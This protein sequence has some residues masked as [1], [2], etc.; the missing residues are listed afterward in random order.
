[1]TASPFENVSPG[2]QRGQMTSTILQCSTYTALLN[3]S[4]LVK[5]QGQC[6]RRQTFPERSKHFWKAAVTWSSRFIMQ[7]RAHTVTRGRPLRCSHTPL[8]A[9]FV[10]CFHG[11]VPP[12][13]A[14]YRWNGLKSVENSRESYFCSLGARCGSNRQKLL[15]ALISPHTWAKN[16][17]SAGPATVVKILNILWFNSPAITSIASMISQFND[18]TGNTQ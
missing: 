2:K 14:A 4:S 15:R 10:C 3:I 18:N 17:N 12:H 5:G 13:S 6:P 8:F 7:T 1:M 16:W 11:N 9:V